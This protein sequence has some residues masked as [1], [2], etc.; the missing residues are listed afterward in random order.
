MLT[1]TVAAV[2]TRHPIELPRIAP[3]RVPEPVARHGV[4]FSAGDGPVETAVY[5]REDFP[6]GIQIEGPAIVGQ[7]D[8][9]TL[10]PPGAVARVDELANLLITV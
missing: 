6:A 2:G 8:A 5:R 1:F 7:V 9:T 3:G 4:I 10:V